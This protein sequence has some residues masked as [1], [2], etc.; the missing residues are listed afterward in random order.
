MG[1]EGVA[2]TMVNG[3][4]KD[5][6]AEAAKATLK[7]DLGAGKKISYDA[8]VDAIEKMGLEDGEEA[9]LYL[10]IPVSM[11]ADLRKDP[12]FKAIQLGKDSIVISGQI[13]WVCG[14]PVAVSKACPAKKAYIGFSDAITLF[15]K[16]DVYVEQDRDIETRTNTVV[17]G[18]VNVMAL[19][20]ATKIVEIVEE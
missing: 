14:V 4:T 3:F 7:Q 19:T 18:V 6:F 15:T 8:V 11:K 1:M 2:K 12:D 9:G 17:S 16:K 13:G 5:Y 20:D 10:L